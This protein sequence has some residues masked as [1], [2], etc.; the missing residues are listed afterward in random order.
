MAYSTF[1]KA[2]IL[3]AFVSVALTANT[4]GTTQCTPI[5]SNMP[6]C[7]QANANVLQLA[8]NQYQDG[9]S[10]GGGGDAIVSAVTSNGIVS[11][12]SYECA[13]AGNVP[14]VLSAAE[15]RA[16]AEKIKNCPSACGY[17]WVTAACS[18]GNVLG[19]TSLD[20]EKVPKGSPLK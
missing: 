7:V 13:G 1:L 19:A 9:V 6:A 3:S 16:Y 15:V 5:G 2:A 17:Y 10:Y 8:I 4:P 14:P 20:I 18:V 11:L 12:L